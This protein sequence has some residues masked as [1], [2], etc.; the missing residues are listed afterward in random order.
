MWQVPDAVHTVV[1]APDDGWR[2]HPKHVEQFPKINKLCNF[3]SCW[4]YIR[5]YLRCTD[6]WMLNVAY[7]HSPPSTVEAKN[8]YS[9]NPPPFSKRTRTSLLCLWRQTGQRCPSIQFTLPRRTSAPQS[10]HVNIYHPLTSHHNCVLECSCSQTSKRDNLSV[11]I[12]TVPASVTRRA[13]KL[14]IPRYN[15]EAWSWR[16]ETISSFSNVINS[17][18]TKNE[19]NSV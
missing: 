9:Y 6:P 7:D 14:N 2:Y 18:K 3:A 5:I 17:L 15:N 8:D 1:C 4:T 19:P 12:N 13:I 10:K 11:E 16:P